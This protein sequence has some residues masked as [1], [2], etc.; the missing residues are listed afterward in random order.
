MSGVK[1]IDVSKWQGE[2]NWAEVRKNGVNFAIIREG[3]GKK[4]ATQIDKQ[5]KRNYEGAKSVGIDVG[6][7]HYSYADSVSDA[8][9]EAEFCLENIKGMQFEYPIVFDIEDKE[10]LK[11][12][13]RQRTDIVKAFCE[14][15]EKA[16]YYAMFY[17]NLYW[18]NNYLYKSELERYD[19]WL[20]QWGVDN[21]T[22]ACGI[23][24][25]SETGRIGGIVGNVDIDVAYRNYPAIIKSKG[26]NGFTNEAP[27][28]EIQ[29]ERPNNIIYMVKRGDTLSKIASRYN[30]D[31][32][33]IA[34]INDIKDVNKIYVGQV[35]SIPPSPTPVYYTVKN[36]DTLTYIAQR[37]GVMTQDIVKLNGL[38]NPNLIYVGQKLRIK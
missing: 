9:L 21:P 29:P 23:W 15:I 19:L 25:K 26:L 7:Y 11:L 3:W 27:I 31:I 14:E 4:S 2:I 17:C 6:C 30:I 32:N 20:A 24:Q 34:K 16:G 12:N 37:Y 10:Q 38:E 13:N 8:R 33:T 35:L 1:G 18:L 5:F 28:E 22:V 36:G